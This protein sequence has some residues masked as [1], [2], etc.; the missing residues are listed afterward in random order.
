MSSSGLDWEKR[1]GALGKGNNREEGFRRR[2]IVKDEG[3]NRGT[4]REGKDGGKGKIFSFTHV[5]VIS[6]FM[7]KLTHV[8]VA[9]VNIVSPTQI[10][11]GKRMY[12]FNPI[13][14]SGCRES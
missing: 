14:C 8:F 10:P 2:G 12:S 13:V 7:M 3:T 4:E 1:C 6:C 9:I 11:L 5:K